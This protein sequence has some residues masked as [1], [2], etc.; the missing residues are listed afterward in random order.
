MATMRLYVGNLDYATTQEE[1][2]EIFENACPGAVTSVS[3]I[4]DRDTRQSKGFA[5]VEM[6]DEENAKKAI[7][8]LNNFQLGNRKL[9]V[10]EARPK[11]D[12]PRTGG[13]GGGGGYRGGNGGGGNR[14]GGQ[15]WY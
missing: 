6:I 14:G 3:L 4:T 8:A 9:V 11:S 13:Q 1:L 15:T 7:E 2:Q 5:F 10:N 12:A